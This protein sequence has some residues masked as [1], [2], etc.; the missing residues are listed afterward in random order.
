MKKIL[1]VVAL[2]L[3]ICTLQASR[4]TKIFLIGDSTCATKDLKRQNPERGWGHM[5][6]P[7]FDEGV[8]VENHARNGRSTKSFRDLGHWAVVAETMSQGDYLFIQFGHND[9]KADD[10]VRYASPEDYASNI[11]GYIN[12][13]KAKGVTPILLTPVV[14]R[15]FKEEGLTG[16]HGDYTAAMKAVAKS[17]NVTLIDMEQVTWEWLNAIGDEPSR[18]YFMWIDE[19]TNPLHPDGRVDNTHYV[20][21]GARIVARFVTEQIAKNIPEL[22]PHVRDWDLVV[23]QDGSGDFFSIQEAINAVPDYSNEPFTIYIADGIY[24][25]K[26]VIPATKN[27]LYING[28]SA[29]RTIISFDNYADRLSIAGHKLGTSGSSTLYIDADN[30]RAEDITFENCAGEVG[31][32]VAVRTSGDNMTFINCRFI[33]DQDTLYLA[34]EGNRDG[35]EATNLFRHYF[36]GCYIEGTTDFIFGAATALFKECTI[37][38]KKNSYITA[39]STCK[40]LDYGF[41]FIDC[42]L[43]AADNVTQCYLGRPWREYAK[44]V[45]INCELGAHIRSEGWHNWSKPHAEKSTLYAEYG[46]YGQGANDAERIKWAK[47]LSKKSIE[48]KYTPEAILNR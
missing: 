43:T 8:E 47:K 12:E 13:A 46:S 5:I 1:F 37:H 30:F 34:G 7:L 19:G 23:A 14:R 27:N 2:L 33:G 32:A 42:K 16:R 17:E 6:A 11:K 22:A 9:A 29:E 36:E 39:A 15:Y 3:T 26:V 10:P 31:Q 44:T 28:Q 25:E 21:A 18:K 35:L 38:S 40:G 48:Q 45:F 41:V 4:P 20:A 24:K